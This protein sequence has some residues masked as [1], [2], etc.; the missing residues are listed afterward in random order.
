[1]KYICFAILLTILVRFS[2]AQNDGPANTGMAFLK[3]P[4]T[5]RALGMGEAVVSNSMDAS[6]TFYNP[7]CLFNGSNVN[8]IFMHNEQI[9]GIRTE[10]LAAKVNVNRVALGI[11]L[12][13]TAVND[14]QVRDIPGPAED[15]FNAQNFAIGLSAAYKINDFVRVGTT[16]KFLYQK[17]YIDNSSG[18][19]FDFGGYYNKNDISAGIA[20]ANLG[21]MSIMRSQATILP[22]FHPVW[23][24]VCIRIP[25][26][27]CRV[28]NWCRWI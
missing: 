26:N 11:S 17:I 24:I 14:I 21:K 28:K 23:S 6:A 16:A 1:M 22:K 19:A 27:Q 20:I 3:L 13:N 5:S 4:I 7:A 9:L 25:E 10:F 8:A 15:V 2:D 18:Y 12:N